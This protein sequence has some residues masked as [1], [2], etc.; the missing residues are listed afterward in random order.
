MFDK[1]STLECLSSP[2]KKSLLSSRGVDSTPSEISPS[3]IPIIDV[4]PLVRGDSSVVAR[5]IGRACRVN[6]FFYVVG[7]GVDTELSERLR[8]FSTRFFALDL[9][10]KMRIRMERGRGGGSSLW[11][12]S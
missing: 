1:G 2:G 12:P 5:E 4:E 9:E 11:V 7:H 6:G 8:C 3:Q 10:D